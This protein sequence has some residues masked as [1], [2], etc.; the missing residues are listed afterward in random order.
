MTAAFSLQR[1]NEAEALSSAGDLAFLHCLDEGVV[2]VDTSSSIVF[3]NRSICSFFGYP[4]DELVGRP[5]DVLL[6]E[7]QRAM[8]RKEVVHFRRSKE[9]HRM[10]G[11]RTGVT[12]RRKNGSEF[13]A[14]VS[15]TKI[16]LQG[17]PVMLA[18]VRDVTERRRAE[19]RLRGSEERLR[20]ILQTCSDAV[21]LID[22]ASGRI[23]E[24]NAGAGALFA[25]RSGTLA[26]VPASLLV[27]DLAGIMRPAGSAPAGPER[28]QVVSETVARRLDGLEVPVEVSA[29]VTEL[30]G[31]TVQVAFIRD[32]SHHKLREAEL[33]RAREA[34]RAA[35]E[36]KIR[37]LANVSHELRTP[38]NAV[39]GM[40]EIMHTGVFGRIE[41][42]KYREYVS[43]IHDSGLHLLAVINDILDFSRL[44]VAKYIVHE[45]D[46]AVPEVVAHCHRT[47]RRLMEEATLRLRASFDPDLALRGDRR[48]LRQMLLNLLSNAIKHTPAGGLITVRGYRTGEG[49]VTLEVT[50]TGAGIPQDRIGS[51]TEPFNLD[52]EIAVSGSGGTGL[53]LSITKRLLELHGGSLGI[54]SAV[55]R[56]TTVRLQFPRERTLLR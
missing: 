18:V 25:L 13:D 11:D 51:I 3:V 40:S 27:P 47:V 15:I 19:A 16:V 20:V 56:G 8:H 2:A 38:L 48:A 34:S 32:I 49:G 36:S 55:G 5:L 10:M 42:S 24:A 7:R 30:A 9:T 21:L 54:E 12:G 1:P 22:V 6:P 52:Q 35:G 31:E 41:N 28:T 17:E 50:D 33:I 23:V 44:E 26:G 39:I 29:A 53:G 43:D 14:E 46:M 45:D 37:F 4:D